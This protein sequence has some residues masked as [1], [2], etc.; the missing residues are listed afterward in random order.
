MLV[1]TTIAAVT[2][3]LL[4]RG[5]NPL[6]TGIGAPAALLV[7]LALVICGLGTII[8]L[9]VRIVLRRSERLMSQQVRVSFRQSLL[10]AALCVLALL[11]S[12]A[13]LFAWWNMLLA[14]C[15]LGIVEYFFLAHETD[16]AAGEQ[17]E[18]YERLS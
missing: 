11:L 3:A 12:H 16:S 5:V 9:S 6:Q 14:V 15:A 18:Q 10:L 4:L 17:G 7:C 1:G 13:R 2:L 8:G